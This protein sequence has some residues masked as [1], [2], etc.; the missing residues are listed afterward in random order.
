MMKQT[1]HHRSTFRI[2]LAT[3]AIAALSGTVACSAA[4]PAPELVEA[5]TAYE[6]AK[7]GPASELAPARLEEARQALE[8]AE[9]KFE[10]DRKSEA[11]KVAAYIAT[12]RA[13]IATI[14]G[15][16]KNHKLEIKKLKEEYD[17]LEKK[18][19]TMTREELA[20]AKAGL[21][22]TKAGLEQTKAQLDAER[23]ARK[24]A[25]SRLA[26]AVAS[27]KEMA[28]VKEEA[29]GVVI[30]LSGSVLFSTG[31][32]K[33]LPI[34]KDKLNDVAKALV[35]QGYKK[36]LVEGHTDSQGS[37]RNNESLSL[38]RAE[39]V[40][41]HLISQGITASKIEAMGLGESRP[42]AGNDTP[43]GRAN[44]R[45]VEIIVE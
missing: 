22:Q 1:S 16:E 21:A 14:R 24:A 43:E 11:A 10:Q 25:E 38:K 32:Y 29:R 37:E 9:N 28:Q 5:R 13:E 31:K 26:S 17:E 35:D 23:E 20:A 34:A 39:S 8:E 12:R 27:L 15:K 45:R 40:R 6:V 33:L 4:P 18:H 44:N 3:L 42:V 30:T 7:N 19:L 36:I 41:T 2:P